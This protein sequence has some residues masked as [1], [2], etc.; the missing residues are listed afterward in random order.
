MTVD[1][2][3]VLVVGAGHAGAEAATAIRQAGH[4]GRI[5]L[6]GEE[7]SLPYHRPPLSKA[8]LAGTA[9]AETLLLKAPAVYEK[10]DIEILSGI[11]VESIDRATKTATLSDGTQIVYSKLVSPPAVARVRKCCRTQ[12]RRQTV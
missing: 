5:V 10:A 12:C 8:Y 3:T 4:V 2:T 9:T 6:V 11:R 1:N 7:N